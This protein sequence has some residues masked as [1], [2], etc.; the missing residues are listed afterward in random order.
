MPLAQFEVLLPPIL[1]GMKQT[2]Q[3]ARFRVVASQVRALVQVAP[4]AGEGQILGRVPAAVLPGN[5]MFCVEGHEGLV[6]LAQP[7]GT[8][9]D[10][11]HAP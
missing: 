7:A 10:D 2:R 4:V 6:I 11:R 9:T 8:R 1:P 5:N 3:F